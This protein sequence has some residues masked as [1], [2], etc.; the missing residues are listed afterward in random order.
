MKPETS[1]PVRIRARD[2]GNVSAWKLPDMTDDERERLIALAQKPE[3]EPITE[4]KVI[5]EEIYAEKLTLTQWEEIVEEARAEGLEQGRQEGFEAG[6]KE[7]LEQGLQQGLDEG[8]AKIDEQL[9]RFDAMIGHLQRPLEEQ[10]Q[11]LEVTLL[12]LVEQLAQAVVQAELSSRPELLASAITEAFACLPPGPGPV[13]IKL[14]PD[15]CALL[16]KQAEIQGWELV[17]EP[18]MTAGGCELLAGAS[19]VDVSVESRF[20]QVADQLKRRLLP[21]AHEEAT[22]GDGE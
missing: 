11:A 14:N 20:A 6:Q 4:V 21:P 7:G 15:D 1:T 17:E 9:Q 12:T 16:A 19:R 10:Q 8:R 13:R 3:P 5:E 2:A 18:A 22:D